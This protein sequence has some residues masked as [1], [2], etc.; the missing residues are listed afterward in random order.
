MIGWADD[1]DGRVAHGLLSRA[2]RRRL[3]RD[4]DRDHQPCRCQAHVIVTG[5]ILELEVDAQ[6]PGRFDR[7]RQGKADRDLDLTI[8]KRDFFLAHRAENPGSPP[9]ITDLEPARWLI[10]APEPGSSA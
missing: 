7:A 2:C 6:L 1:R 5:L 9:G 8:V 10:R 4:F 3:D